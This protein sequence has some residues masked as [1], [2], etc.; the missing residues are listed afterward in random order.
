VYADRD[1]AAGATLRA[2]PALPRDH[3][4][5]PRGHDLDA[6]AA[7]VGPRTKLVYLANPNNPT[8]THF[9]IDALAGFLQKVPPEVLSS[10]TRRTRNSS[11]GAHRRCRCCRNIPT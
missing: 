11:N 5:M 8:G 2:A 10:S 1:A 9:T 6:I 4:T 3:A 7:A